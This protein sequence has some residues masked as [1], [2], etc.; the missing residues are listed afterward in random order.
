M[1]AREAVDLLRRIDSFT[2]G[3]PVTTRDGPNVCVLLLSSTSTTSL[4]AMQKSS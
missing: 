3:E 2:C 4:R 1:T